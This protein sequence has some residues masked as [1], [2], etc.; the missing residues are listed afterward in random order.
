VNAGSVPAEKAELH[1]IDGSDGIWVR[2]I[3]YEVS[4]WPPELADHESASTWRIVVAYR[5]NGKWALHYA[6]KSS[7][8]VMDATGQWAWDYSMPDQR[9]TL[10]EAIRL[11]HEH[12][13]KMTIND[14]TALEVLARYQGRADG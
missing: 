4:V 8:T 1:V 9:F 14:M 13:P 6:D 3:A 12:A 2:P 10:R 5:G 7:Q 11:A